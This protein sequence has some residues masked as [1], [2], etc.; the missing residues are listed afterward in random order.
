MAV[1][2]LLQV[3]SGQNTRGVFPADIFTCHSRGSAGVSDNTDNFSFS[4][5]APVS[6]LS[7][8]MYTIPGPWNCFA[9]ME[10]TAAIVNIFIDTCAFPAIACQNV[11]PGKG[12]L[13]A[14]CPVPGSL[15]HKMAQ[16][17]VCEPLRCAGGILYVSASLCHSLKKKK[18]PKWSH[19][20]DNPAMSQIFIGTEPLMRVW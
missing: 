10:F 9:Y 6:H 2:G 8:P 7:E 19:Q 15:S 14:L 13:A 5:S 3:C 4:L 17:V 16:E 20:R 11:S 12:P 1:Q 18:I